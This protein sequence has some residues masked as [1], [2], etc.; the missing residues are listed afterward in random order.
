MRALIGPKDVVVAGGDKRFT[1]TEEER[2]STRA[3][4]WTKSEKMN[5][6]WKEFLQAIRCEPLEQHEFTWR[7]I[8]KRKEEKQEETE[9]IEADEE[10]KRQR[11]R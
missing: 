1:L 9:T 4:K 10:Q 3:T 5:T 8:A 6:T 11:R 7:R 2:A